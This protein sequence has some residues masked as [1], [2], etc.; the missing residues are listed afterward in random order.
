M[1]TLFPQDVQSSLSM[2]FVPALFCLWTPATFLVKTVS[3]KPR[4]QEFKIIHN[5]RYTHTEHKIERVLVNVTSLPLVV[6]G[7]GYDF[8]SLDKP[9]EIFLSGRNRF[10]VLI[11]PNRESANEFL[12]EIEYN[13]SEETPSYS[14]RPSFK[15]FLESDKSE[16]TKKFFWLDDNSEDDEIYRARELKEKI[17]NHDAKKTTHF[18]LT[19]KMA[20]TGNRQNR[21]AEMRLDVYLD[22]KKHCKSV[23][24]LFRTAL[25]EL[26]EKDDWKMTVTYEGLYPELADSLQAGDKKHREMISTIALVWGPK[27]DQEQKVELKIQGEQD[28]HLRRFMK[29]QLRK[30]SLSAMEKHALVEKLNHLNQYKLSAKYNVDSDKKEI[31]N[32]LMWYLRFS[33][34]FNAD[35]LR[36]LED[37]VA[38]DELFAKV[39]FDY[40]QLQYLNA[41]INNWRHNLTV[42]EYKLPYSVPT[43]TYMLNTLTFAGNK[44]EECVV[45]KSGIQTFLN[46][47]QQGQHLPHSISKKVREQI[48]LVYHKITITTCFM[49]LLFSFV[50]IHFLAFVK[51]FGTLKLHCIS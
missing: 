33:S 44:T 1:F 21:R 50:W 24:E 16:E 4:E 47:F 46:K 27:D 48:S 36:N 18:S 12:T 32:G 31:L 13:L 19:V 41:S 51:G 7:Y 40:D 37:T 22:D 8:F 38:K 26:N 25:P 20:A 28:L 17:R 45:E 30:N 9:L 5:R 29:S 34:Y 14:R 23:V 42:Y 6:R 35:D 15:D 11:Q 10:E 3:E 43:M 39:T 2:I 49:I